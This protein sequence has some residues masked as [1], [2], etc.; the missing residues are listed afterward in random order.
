MCATSMIFLPLPLPF[1][2]AMRSPSLPTLIFVG[3]IFDLGAD[4]GAHFVFKADRPETLDEFAN[5][6][7]HRILPRSVYF[8]LKICGV[9][10][11]TLSRTSATVAHI[12][13]VDQRRGRMEIARRNRNRDRRHTRSGWNDAAGIGAAAARLSN[14]I[15]NLQRVARLDEVLHQTRI[16]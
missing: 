15:R 11:A 4:D 16:G 5:E 8:L 9:K 13:Q 14:L 1:F 10:R 7:F 12:V 6:F 2:T 3:Q